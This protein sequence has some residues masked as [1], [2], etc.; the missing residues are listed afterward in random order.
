MFGWKPV[1]FDLIDNNYNPVKGRVD[2]TS[3]GK[4]TL[5]M[6]EATSVLTLAQV[7]A[8]QFALADAAKYLR[9]HETSSRL[10]DR[11]L[12]GTPKAKRP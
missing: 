7:R 8:L 5:R 10:H 12:H 6:E 11:L 2:I 4:I 9:S 3:N 1:E